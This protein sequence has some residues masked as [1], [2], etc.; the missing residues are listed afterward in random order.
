MDG[1]RVHGRSA[2]VMPER[3][4]Q[5]WELGFY[6]NSFPSTQVILHQIPRVNKW[7]IDPSLPLPRL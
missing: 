2:K 6:G 5:L 3:H 7:D 1:A 4:L